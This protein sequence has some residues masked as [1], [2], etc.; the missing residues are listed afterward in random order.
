VVDEDALADGEERREALLA[1]EDD[2]DSVELEIETADGERLT[3]ESR[4]ESLPS[5]N[6][7]QGTAGVV[8]D[9]TERKRHESGLSRYETL[10]EESKDVNVIVEPDGTFRYLTPSASSVFGYDPEELVGEMGFE[11]IHPD[12]RDEAMAE[13]AKIV[14]TPSYEPRMDFRFEHKDGSWIVL[15]V[16]ARD[17]R[18]DPDVDGIV[19]YTRDVTERKKRERALEESERRYRTLVENYPNGAVILFDE[20]LQYLI[21]GGEAFEGLGVSTADLEGDTIHEHVPAEFIDTFEPRFRAVFEGQASDFEFE[22]NDQIRQFRVVPVRDESG[23]VFAGLAISQDVT[24]HRGHE[25]ELERQ[26]KQL[27]ALNKLNGIVRE[28]T[29]AVIDQ[30]TRGEIEATVCERLAESN[31]YEFAWIAEADPQSQSVTPHVEAG[32]DGYLEEITLSIDPDDPE[33]QGPSG[34]ALRTREVQTTQDALSDPDFVPW[35]EHAKEYGY[36]S[37]AAIPIVYEDTLYGLLGVYADRPKAFEGQE[38]D[39]IGQLGEVIGHA[40]AAIERKQALTSDELTEIEFVVP[41]IAELA[42]LEMDVDGTIAFDRAVSTGDDTYLEYGTVDVDAM[43]ALEGL[44]DRL[45]HFEE[46][47]IIDRGAETARFELRLSEPPVVSAVASQGGYLQLASIE[48]GD[49]CLTIHLPATVEARRIIEVVQDAY[50]TA[51]LLRRRQITRSDDR[52]ARIHQAVA[53]D[54]TDRQRATLEAASHAGFFEWPRKA[55]GAE[56]AEALG[57]APSTFS[58]HLRKGQRQVFESLFSTSTPT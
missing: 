23:S 21:A 31:S 51:D 37:S 17:L 34:R 45:S 54:L 42:G 20:D 35:R 55:T 13:F 3:V 5:D 56:V 48:D 39:V 47:T 4:H 38:Q 36:R 30:S 29:E 9:V 50:P 19:V 25:R 22:F 46:M 26:R 33:G 49:F 44:V 10:F 53:G 18:D 11:Y 57:I 7:F 43:D 52:L 28:I 27:A 16:L 24:R 8:R 12:D 14:E 58:Q 40:I 6:G 41:D 15:E 1:G 2:T 32:V